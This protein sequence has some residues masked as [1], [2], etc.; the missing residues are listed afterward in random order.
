VFWDIRE[1]KRREEEESC[2]VRMED[3]R[4]AMVEWQQAHLGQGCLH[5]SIGG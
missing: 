5:W 3:R 1:G 2:T 4:V